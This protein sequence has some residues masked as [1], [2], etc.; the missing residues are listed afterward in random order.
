MWGMKMHG[1]YMLVPI[2]GVLTLSYFVLVVNRKVDSKGLKSFGI[3]IVILLWLVAAA[4][5]AKGVY[6][7]TKRKCPSTWKSKYEM[8]RMMDK[9]MDG[10]MM[11]QKS[12]MMK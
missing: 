1:L 9:P 2:V 12:E 7:M 4:G 8:K 3:I 10:A 11:E 6:R 5:I